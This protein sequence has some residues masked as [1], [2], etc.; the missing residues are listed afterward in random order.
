[1]RTVSCLVLF[2]TDCSCDLQLMVD[3]DGKQ[4]WKHCTE[5]TG[6]RLPPGYYFGAS[7]ATGDLSGI[8]NHLF[9]CFA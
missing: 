2:F 9:A 7:S 1:M 8:K 6:L 3:V 4:E 5:I